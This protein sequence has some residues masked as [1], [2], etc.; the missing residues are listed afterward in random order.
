[1]IDGEITFIIG[2]QI[3]KATPGMTIHVPPNTPHAARSDRAGR[4][5]T[6]FS[7][8]GV[9]G[10]LKAFA[11]LTPEQAQ[12]PTVA[13]AIDGGYAREPSGSRFKYVGTDGLER[14]YGPALSAGGIVLHHSTATFDGHA[15]GVE[16][17]CDEWAKVKLPPQAGLAIYE[18]AGPD[19]IQAMRIYDD[20]APP[21]EL[22]A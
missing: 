3:V 14:F 16:Y 21:F 12:N 20:V 5:L 11:A 15:C 7:P 4:M 6:L 9:G 10:A 2:N 1:L 8:A 18:L 17:V 19:R 22:S 13:Q